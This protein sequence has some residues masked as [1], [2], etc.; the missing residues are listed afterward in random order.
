MELLKEYRTVA[1]AY[2]DK[3]LLEENDINCVIIE[4]ALSSIYP[5]PDAITGR[6]KLYVPDGML[7]ISKEILHNTEKQA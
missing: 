4:D 7:Q 1:D 5:A 2:I 6:I 3:G